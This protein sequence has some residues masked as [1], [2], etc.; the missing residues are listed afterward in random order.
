MKPLAFAWRGLVRQPARAV[1]GIVGVAAA[2]AVDNAAAAA[3]PMP[4]TARAG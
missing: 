2:A 4:S 1:L 3:T